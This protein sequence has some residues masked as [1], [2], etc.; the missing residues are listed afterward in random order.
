MS[1]RLSVCLSQFK[2]YDVDKIAACTLLLEGTAVVNNSITKL[3]TINVITIG[4][5]HTGTTLI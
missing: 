2:G 1:V 3:S 4:G 5:V